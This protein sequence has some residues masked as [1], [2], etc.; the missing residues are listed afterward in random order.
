MAIG[1]YV[2]L[3]AVRKSEYAGHEIPPWH[4]HCQAGEQRALGYVPMCV[5]VRFDIFLA[6]HMEQEASTTATSFK[7]NECTWIVEPSASS[8]H[9]HADAV[10]LTS[11]RSLS[12]PRQAS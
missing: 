5:Q 11:Q 8:S 12:T 6:V 9:A 10:D 3:V 1:Q 7:T 2:R 4:G